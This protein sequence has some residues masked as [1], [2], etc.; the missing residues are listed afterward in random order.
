MAGFEVVRAEVA[1]R[2]VAAGRVVK[3]FD[4][5]EHPP[6]EP[7]AGGS[8]VPVVEFALQRREKRLGDLVVQRVANGAHLTWTPCLGLTL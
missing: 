4:V 3:R 2:G 8:G 6:G 5:V 1:E 7:G